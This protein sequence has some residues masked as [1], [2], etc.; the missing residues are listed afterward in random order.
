MTDKIYCVML[1]A[2][3]VLEQ[4]SETEMEFQIET[5][6]FVS[7]L[8]PHIQFWLSNKAKLRAGEDTRP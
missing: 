7:D 8:E 2:T 4:I 1:E 5:E 6:D 3:G